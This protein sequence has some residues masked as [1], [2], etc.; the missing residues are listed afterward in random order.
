MRMMALGQFFFDAG[1]EV[2]FV[3]VRYNTQLVENLKWIALNG[4]HFNAIMN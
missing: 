1:H 2:H 3:T 4:H